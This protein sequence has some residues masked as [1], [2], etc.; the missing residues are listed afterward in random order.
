MNS[1]DY[2][3]SELKRLSA[4]VNF[5]PERI[6]YAIDNINEFYSEHT[7]PKK[8]KK[9][10][11]LCYV[12]GTP[13]TRTICPSRGDLKF[14]QHRLKNRVLNQY[15][16]PKNIHGG[17]KGRS[18]I[19]N[20][21]VHQ[22]NKYIFMTDLQNFYPSISSKMV[23]SAMVA[24]GAKPY[25][26]SHISKLTTWKNKVPQGAP[27]STHISN[28][29]F[30][31]T[32]KKLIELCD[33]RGITYTRYI[34][35]LTFS[36]PKDFREDIDEILRIIQNDG[37]KISRRKTVYGGK[38]KVITGIEV[39][40]NKIDVPEKIRNLALTEVDLPIKPYTNYC[41]RVWATNK[42]IYR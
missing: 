34:D 38:I 23:Y 10:N 24:L 19:T 7:T 33:Q 6:K 31:A 8:N 35:D 3:K 18:N 25:F 13:K 42:K 4:I 28:L 36:S 17:V 16:L 21:K 40:H 11:V 41:N 30:F 9:G 37:F 20:A 32:D 27:T 2:R 14:L 15:V 39:Y 1:S 26:A 29:V 5:S 12:D 22:G